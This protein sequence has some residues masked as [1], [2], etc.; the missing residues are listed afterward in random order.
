MDKLTIT[1]KDPSP[2]CMSCG[3]KGTFTPKGFDS[4]RGVHT[5]ITQPCHCTEIIRKA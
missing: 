4:K 2:N 1:K 3:G 5:F